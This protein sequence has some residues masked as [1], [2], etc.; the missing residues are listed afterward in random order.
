[1]PNKA[2]FKCPPELNAIRP[3]LFVRKAS[4]L[5][6]SPAFSL[7]EM[8]RTLRVSQ[9]QTIEESFKQKKKWNKTK[10]KFVPFV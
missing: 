3:S 10:K 1:M 5:A 4:L 6:L 9:I 2:I 8:K 7:L